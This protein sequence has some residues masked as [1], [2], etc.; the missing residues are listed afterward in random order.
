MLSH[1]VLQGPPCPWHLPGAPSI[2]ARLM[3]AYACW[4]SGRIASAQLPR[5]CMLSHPAGAS[6]CL[7]APIYFFVP[8][9]R[10]AGIIAPMMDDLSIRAYPHSHSWHSR[11]R[12]GV[13]RCSLGRLA[14]GTSPGFWSWLR[15]TSEVCRQASEGRRG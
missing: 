12:G 11:T 4:M 6:Q 15:G 9:P 2:S 13:R 14:S 1:N 8:H 3:S 10:H 5:P 7:P